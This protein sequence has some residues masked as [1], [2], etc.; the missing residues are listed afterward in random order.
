[1]TDYVKSMRKL[2]GHAPM[3]MVGSAVLLIKNKDD[4]FNKNDKNEIL[5]QRRRDNGMWAVHGGA[6]EFNEEI[7]AAARRE[8]REETGLT[9]GSLELFGVF[10][11][12]ALHYVYP[13][14]DEVSIVSAVYICRDWTGT[15][16]PQTE[17]VLEL[18]YFPIDALPEDISPPDKPVLARLA[19]EYDA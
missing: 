8:L 19:A 17:E 6:A 4:K 9:A 14:G 11:G 12:P 3:I 7:E 10:S 16:N 18:R 15:P 1:M 5:L 13:N 2:I